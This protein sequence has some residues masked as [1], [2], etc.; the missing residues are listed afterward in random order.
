MREERKKRK[1]LTLNG[2]KTEIEGKGND[3]KETG[4]REEELWS[5]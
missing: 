4:G 3:G 2:R 1:I 5:K